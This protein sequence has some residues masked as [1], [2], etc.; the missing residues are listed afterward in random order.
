MKDRI[1][2]RGKTSG[3]S[4]DNEEAIKERLKVFHEITQPVVDFYEKQHKLKRI[5]AERPAEKVY[6]DVKTVFDELD[7]LSGSFINVLR[8]LTFNV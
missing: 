4:D 5:N 6:D 8:V 1:L 7:L 3:R 2:Q